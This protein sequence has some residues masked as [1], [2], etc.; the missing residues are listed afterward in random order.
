MDSP[1]LFSVTH[2][3]RTV[4]LSLSPSSSLASL[5][6]TLSNEFDLSPSSLKLLF[7]G[8]KLAIDGGEA[9]SLQEVLERTFGPTLVAESRTKP[10]K[11]LL[12]GTKRSEIEAMEAQDALR[13]KKHDAFL[14]HQ[15]H[16]ARP[17][18]RS[19][20]HSLSDSSS[21][22]AHFRFHHLEPF[23][24]SVPFF[25]RRKAMLERLAEDPAVKDVMRRHKFAVGVLTELHPTLHTNFSTG[26]KLLGLNTNAGQKISLRLLTDD[27]DGLRAYNDVRRVLLH[28]LSHNRFGDHDNNFKELNSLLNREVAAYE[29]SPAFEPWDPPSASSA[30]SAEEHRL[31]EEAAEKADHQLRFG[32][33]DFVDERR[34]KAGRAAEERARKARE[35]GGI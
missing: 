28:E 16:Q 33:E 3:G 14:F 5:A 34:E 35:Q 13:R 27:L 4:D 31:N 10:I 9:D 20:V 24:K 26:E 32:L 25:D 1:I 7:K 2:A 8:K 12:V 30:R 15:Q 19:G 29:S 6:D 21:D 11:A 22:P 18:S 17:S 23:P